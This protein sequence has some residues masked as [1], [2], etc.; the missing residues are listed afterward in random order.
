MTFVWCLLCLFWAL[1]S[2]YFKFVVLQRVT[3]IWQKYFNW[4]VKLEFSKEWKQLTQK[5]RDRPRWRTFSRTWGH[6]LR[7][8]DRPKTRA[9]RQLYK[10]KRHFMQTNSLTCDLKVML[11]VSKTQILV[12]PTFLNYFNKFTH[13]YRS[14]T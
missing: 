5:K 1:P 3:N 11:V 4:I 9:C 12:T 6:G 14:K 10:S 8:S 7:S 2:T 13:Q